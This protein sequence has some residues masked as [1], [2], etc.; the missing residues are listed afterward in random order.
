A[1]AIPSAA[2]ALLTGRSRYSEP[3]CLKVLQDDGWQQTP[4]C[5]AQK[6]NDIAVFYDKAGNA[7]HSG[8]I[9]KVILAGPQFNQNA[10]QRAS[11]SGR[12]GLDTISF[13]ISMGRY[14]QPFGGVGNTEHYRCSTKQPLHGCCLPG[15][16]EKLN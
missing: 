10:S 11:K 13:A 16:H 7:T 3:M 14:F 15:K 4:C 9:R 8:I 5:M 1:T 2:V 12:F 6:D